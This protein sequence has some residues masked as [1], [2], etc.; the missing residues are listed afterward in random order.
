MTDKFSISLGDVIFKDIDQNPYLNELYENILYNYS[1][2]LFQIK[3]EKKPVNVSDALRF[4]DILSKSSSESHM[5]WAQEIVALLKETEPNSPEID[6]YLN[7]VLSSTG[8]YQGLETVEKNQP[9]SVSLRRSLLERF[10]E[11]YSKELMSIPAEPD[12]LFF[13]PQRQIYDHLTKPYFS[14]SGP[15]SMG[16]SFI[17]RM[18]IKKQVQDNTKF[19]YAL[20]VPTKALINEVSS[21]IISDLGSLLKEKNY[22]V[23]TSAGA[24]ALEEEHNFIYV[25]TPERLLYLLIR[26]KDK[27]IDYLFIDEAHKITSKD[28]RSTFYYKDIDML[29]QRERKPHVVFASPNIPN[30]EV[31]LKLVPEALEATDLGG[32]KLATSFSPVSQVKYLIDCVDGGIHIFNDRNSRLMEISRATIK[33]PLSKIVAHLGNGVQTIVYFNSK[34]KAIQAAIDYAAY[35]QDKGDRE[36][37]ALAKEIANQVHK[38][39]FLA[40]LIKKGIAYHIGYLP[41][42]I[43]MKIE[44]LF[45]DKKIV[46]MFCTSTLVEGVNLPADNLFITTYR[47]GRGQTKM[48]AVDFRNLVGRVGRINYNLYGNVFLV[49]LEENLKIEDFVELLEKKVPEQKLSLVTELKPNQKRQ[50]I[51][52]LLQGHTNL[53]KEKGQS[54]DSFDLTR[55]FCL[56]LLRDIMQGRNSIVKREFSGF[57]TSEDERKIKGAFEKDEIKPDDD[58]NTSVDQTKSLSANI[59][60]GLAYPTIDGDGRTKQGEPQAFLE[61]LYDIFGWGKCES[62]ETIGNKNRLRWYAV[63]LRH[64]VSGNGLGM[65]IDRSLTYAQN[66]ANYKVRIGSQ[67]ILYN[68]NSM[69]HRNIV[70]SETLQAIESVVLFSFAN[71][72]LRFSEAY[73]RIHNIEG[74]MD[75]D[76]YEFVEYGTINKLTIF[77]QR[78][79]FSRE[80]A[81]FIRQH[82]NEYVIGLDDSKPVKIKKDILNCENF[83]VIAEV[84]DMS[85]NNP[86]LP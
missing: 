54:Q 77:L 62:S 50:I 82:R 42:S 21:K 53:E 4:A 75:N 81:L 15:T 31:Y 45:R 41:A 68:H 30:P 55:K 8:N 73:K 52:C 16:K 18:F 60:W 43:R 12:K 24:L 57:L 22:R 2:H 80:T 29:A 5:T 40:R 17:M 37:D 79:G 69:M 9:T 7:S 65:I 25:L 35:E 33:V 11:E 26:H 32:N 19:N 72:F 1:L 66:N 58:I 14:Y 74:E 38:D 64:W 51:A 49:R 13:R 47:K 61:K 39:Y 59:A 20:I 63:I 27:D 76:W 86:D 44:K 70:M 36:L 71:Y 48:T 23:V 56:I 46:V 67:L 78:N 84:E 85:I 3:S 6:I 34:D 83:S 10:H 28:K